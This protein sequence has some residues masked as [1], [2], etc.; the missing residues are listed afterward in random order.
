M[1]ERTLL[2]IDGDA[3]DRG[4]VIGHLRCDSNFAY[5]VLEADTIGAALK[6]L[7]GRKPDCVVLCQQVADGSALDFLRAVTD[8]QG[9][10][11]FPVIVLTA[12]GGQETAVALMKAGALDCLV[13]TN[14]TAD[15]VRLAVNNAIYQVRVERRMEEQQQ[16]LKRLYAESS[17][18]NE[19]LRAAN[20]A[21]DDFLAMLS[22]ELRTPLTPVLSLVSA[23]SGDS[24]LTPALRETFAVIQR[25]VELEAR[26]ID[27]LLDLTQI[28]SGRLKIEKNPVDIHRCIEGALEIC[29]EGLEEKRIQLSCKLEAENPMVMGESA[30]LNQVFWNLLKNAIKFTK[31]HGHV[32]I[33]TANDHDSVVIE[34]SDDGQGIEPERL[35]GVFGTF[36]PIKPNPT[37]TGIGL[38]LAIT[39]AVVEGHG[40]TIQAESQGPNKGA[41]F[42][43]RIP[44]S[45]DKPAVTDPVVPNQGQTVRGKSILVVEDHDDTR[46]ALARVL[47]RKGFQVRAA[48]S[49]AAAYE[50]FSIASPDLMI[51]DIG[52]SDGTGWDLMNKLHQRWPVR[53]IAVSGYGMEHDLKRSLDAGF[54][55]HLTKPIN[56]SNLETMIAKTLSKEKSKITHGTS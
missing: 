26:L 50:Q 19:E 27:D 38:G 47:Q 16:E 53:A 21:K 8:A 10:L 37:A 5:T 40:G 9:K 45:K 46:R 48:G 18:H 52:L 36:H 44:S 41:L 25:N 17:V 55:E 11:P 15:A 6:M 35:P 20:S 30:R 49:V 33:R 56:I 12:G 14:A 54:L 3:E 22:H 39:R 23:T 43:I 4:N 28:S 29:Q 34:V 31:P 2:I 1:Q 13:K 51:C 7:T 42:R 24:T 32:N